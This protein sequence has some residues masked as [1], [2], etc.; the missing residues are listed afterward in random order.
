MSYNLG[1]KKVH[2]LSWKNAMNYFQVMGVKQT[3][4]A[5]L[6]ASMQG[7]C[8]AEDAEPRSRASLCC[9]GYV[10]VELLPQGQS[11]AQSAAVLRA[12]AR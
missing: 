3:W 1:P 2:R 4:D 5:C 11:W 8:G 12:C 7:G 10:G 6:K 9:G